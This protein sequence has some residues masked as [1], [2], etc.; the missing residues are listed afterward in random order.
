M[1][2]QGIKNLVVGFH[3]EKEERFVRAQLTAYQ[4]GNLIFEDLVRTILDKKPLAMQRVADFIIAAAQLVGEAQ[5]TS[6]P[7]AS[8]A[9]AADQSPREVIDK[10]VS[11]TKV[12]NDLQSRVHRAL[13]SFAKSVRNE[14]QVFEQLTKPTQQ[15]G[16]GLG[17]AAANSA[18][19]KLAE[20]METVGVDVVQRGL[21]REASL[22]GEA[23][24]LPI[25]A[26]APAKAQPHRLFEHQPITKLE[27]FA[28][29]I[30]EHQ[31]TA[32]Q[33][34]EIAPPTP[35]VRR[36]A[37]ESIGTKT[38]SVDTMI[39]QTVKE[40]FATTPD[41][42]SAPAR[43]VSDDIARVV[44]RPQ[45]VSRKAVPQQLKRLVDQETADGDHPLPLKQAP[46]P[47]PVA[48]QRTEIRHPGFFARLFG[49]SAKQLPAPYAPKKPTPPVAQQQP[50]PTLDDVTYTPRLFSATDELAS[51]TVQDFRRLSANP[52]TAADKLRMKL[53]VLAQD[54]LLKR[55]DG[56]AAL[57]QSPLYK[58]YADILNASLT[59]GMSFGQAVAAQKALTQ[60]EFEAIMAFNKTLQA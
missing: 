29:H 12:S 39:Q 36:V 28:A 10:L 43:V 35:A 2:E 6:L 14:L 1:N 33:P 53:E 17:A 23:V 27:E 37:Q 9:S 48:P 5:V 22:G 7:A 19:A 54:S 42:A 18:I 16:A 25:D 40:L 31:K 41:N 46:V 44:P 60:E 21:E 57:Q 4:A 20:Y 55:K 8:A 59:K 38:S 56:L 58:A 15:G 51:L 30:T 13:V 49:R 50:R 32:R 11:A 45:R 24:D 3:L 34:K 52:T 47:T 26:N